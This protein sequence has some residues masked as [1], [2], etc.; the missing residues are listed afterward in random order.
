MSDWR[1]HV[2]AEPGKLGGKPCVRGE[3]MSVADVLE[4]LAADMSVEEIGENLSLSLVHR[5][6]DL[7]PDSAHVHHPGFDIL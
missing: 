6:A 4:Y 2:I 1:S 3:R 7:F 5:L